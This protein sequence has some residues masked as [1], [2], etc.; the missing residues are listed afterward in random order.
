MV[1][2]HDRVAP[3]RREFAKT[4]LGASGALVLAARSRASEACRDAPPA[5]AYHVK[6]TRAL[7]DISASVAWGVHIEGA[8]LY[9]EAFTAAIAKEKPNLLAIGSGLK[10]GNL[11]PLSPA[12]ERQA[13]GKKFSTWTE[14]DDLVRLAQKLGISTRGDA[15][16]WNDWL[17]QWVVD[18]AAKRP[19][20]WRDAL[21]ESFERNFAAIFAHVDELDRQYGRP[22]MPWRGLVNEPF[23]FWNMAGGGTSWR[24]GAW[25][26][27][28]D[29][30]TDGV[31]GY[32]HKAFEIAEKHSSASKPA[33]Y[34]N[35]ANCEDD[36]YGPALRPAMLALVDSL[37]KA[38]RKLDAIGLEAH[39]QPEWMSDPLRPNWRGFVDFL[40]ELQRRGVKVYLTELDVND[41]FLTDAK[42]RD[43]LVADYTYSFAAAALEVPAV[44]MITHWDFSD[45]ASWYRDKDTFRALSHWK[46]CRPKPACPRP[47]P[48]DQNLAPKAARDALARAF[49]QRR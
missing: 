21:A 14:V 6:E 2:R 33:L 18:L 39:L 24:Q 43:R 11:H 23:A 30:R 3:S 1:F 42:Q 19:P 9:D 44:T 26:D 41:C 16:A 48:Y 37:Q 46:G 4:M 15:I 7:G 31:P 17:P 29:A 20:G 12:F 40:K 10:F 47:T 34:L 8:G 28:F 25:L 49:S 13:D 32:I 5:P 36:T 22:T 35:E 38:G 45:D 27:A